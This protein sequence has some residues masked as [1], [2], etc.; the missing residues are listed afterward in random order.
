MTKSLPASA[1][2]LLATLGLFAP[3]AG[4]VELKDALLYKDVIAPVLGAKCVSCHGPE[5]QKGKLR[6]DSIEALLK[7][8][9]DASIKPGDAKG[10]L[11]LERIHLPLDDDEHMP[12]SDEP[13]L[14]KEEVA[15]LELWVQT[16]AKTDLKVVDAKPA[17][18]LLKTVE[19]LLKNP[20][21]SSVAVAAP[22]EDPKEIEAKVKAATPVI[23][24]VEKA[25]AS[26]MQIAQD[27]SDLR[28]SALNVAAEFKD[29]GLAPL[30]PVAE[31]IRW[32]DLARTKVGDGGL[33]HVAAMKHLAR[34]HLENTAVTDTGLDHLKNL[35]E[36]EYLNLYGTKVSDAGVMKLAGLK[37]LK[38]IF[39]WQ[40]QVTEDGA[41]KLEQ[42]VPGL[43][44]NIGWKEAPVVAAVTPPPAPAPAKEAAKPAA[45]A[46]TPAPAKPAT[47]PAPAPA[48]AKPAAA[49]APAPTPPTPTPAPV[50]AKPAA[51]PPAPAPTP[52]PAAPPAPAA[53]P[54]LTKALADAEK[55][56]ADAKK[57]AEAAQKAATD[58]TNAAKQAQTVVDA[59]RKASAPPA[60]KP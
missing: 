37:N 55:A 52:A 25:G 7:G 3:A 6:M 59:L 49:P 38:K 58:A 16:G 39:L 15:L 8:G 46:P 24:A 40:T 51:T 14:S 35:S 50:P 12:P 10:S 2:L 28:F 1:G 19:A 13:Q 26:L 30:K 60:P 45:P 9:D 27:T 31:Q 4:A 41:K 18:N 44:V 53:N 34:L 48:P 20:P 54:E 56:A 42:A 36:L 47:P 43:A 17:E 23:A 5:K 32:M 11:A 33:A 22:K 21:K 57:V 29:D